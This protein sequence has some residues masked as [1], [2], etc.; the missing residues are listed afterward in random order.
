MNHS[1]LRAL[2]ALL[3]G[4]AVAPLY[5]QTFTY[6]NGGATG[7]WSTPANW[8]G[9]LVYPDSIGA[10][11]VMNTGAAFTT[12]LDVNATVGGL[13]NTAGSARI[14]THTNAGGFTLTL[15]GTGFTNGF[16]NASTAEIRVGSSGGIVSAANLSLS[17][18]NLDIG[19]ASSNNNNAQVTLSGAISATMNQTITIRNNRRQTNLQGSIG[20]SGAGEISIVN[21]SSSGT[22]IGDPNQLNISGNLGPKVVQLTQG[23]G[24]T[25]GMVISG[26]NAAFSGDVSV[27]ANSITVGAAGT[28]GDFNTISVSN[29]ASL[30]LQ[31]VN[32]L[33]DASSLWLDTSGSAT[34][35]F[36]GTMSIS[37]LSLDGGTTFASGGSIWG[38]MGSGAPFESGQFLGAGRLE[39]IPEPSTYA[40]AV[41]AG[42][43]LIA[44]RRRRP[45]A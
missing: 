39:V 44:L 45:C 3:V 12:A 40:L 9:S 4:T 33:G 19:T 35:G 24:V 11:A 6:N 13:R 17:N 26:A 28:L 20:A 1:Q 38:A 27:L 10:L 8:T 18:T 32:A 41:G 5:S 22:G 37:A 36:G 29:G 25:T 43:L 42:A 23:V 7:L 21:L 16:G 2:A 34:L 14:W 30:I 15:D 31:N